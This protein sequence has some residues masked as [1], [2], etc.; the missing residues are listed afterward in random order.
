[1]AMLSTNLEERKKI[2]QTTATNS[3]LQLHIDKN[4]EIYNKF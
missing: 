1:M 3:G 2:K 4:K